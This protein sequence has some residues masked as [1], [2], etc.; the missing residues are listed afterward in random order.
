M[1]GKNYKK[2]KDKSYN[3]KEKNKIW[4]LI[5]AYSDNELSPDEKY[6]VMKKID[7]DDLYKESLEDV[8]KLKNMIQNIE[9]KKVS[10]SFNSDLMEKIKKNEDLPKINN[11]IISFKTIAFRVSS[12]VA[13]AAIFAMVLI[14][15]IRLVN[16]PL[17]NNN[18]FYDSSIALEEDI[19]SG[20]SYDTLDG[21]GTVEAVT[22]DVKVISGPDEAKESREAEIT[23]SEEYSQNNSKNKSSSS[24]EK[25]ENIKKN[26]ENKQIKPQLFNNTLEYQTVD[27]IDEYLKKRDENSEA[28]SLAMLEE[29][30][31]PDEEI[32]MDS[33]EDVSNDLDK[34]S[35]EIKTASSEI[36]IPPV[37][38]MRLENY[39]NEISK[40]DMLYNTFMFSI[41][42]QALLIKQYGYNENDI[43]EI[44]AEKTQYLTDSDYKG[45]EVLINESIKSSGNNRLHLMSSKQVQDDINELVEQNIIIRDE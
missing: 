41:M 24:G 11:N 17:N 35:D 12:G 39:F 10:D 26:I 8:K 18:S 27:D 22:D 43:E 33:F 31:S 37:G 14:F 34:M 21:N 20:F 2:R 45:F 5:S 6:K 3:M 4:E 32:A 13:V 25:L 29:T 1:K 30:D 23:L 7:S 44:I 19:D 38:S 42:T 9:S 16:T 15:T 40:E 36:G 28:T